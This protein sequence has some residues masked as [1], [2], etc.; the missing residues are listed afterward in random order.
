MSDPHILRMFATKPCKIMYVESIARTRT[1]S[2]SAKIL[3]YTRIVDLMLV[4]WQELT[5]KYPRTKFAGRLY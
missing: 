1:L 2:L 3:Y 4:Q 5:V